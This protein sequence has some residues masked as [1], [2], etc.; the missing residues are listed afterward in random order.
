MIRILFILDSFPVEIYPPNYDINIKYINM[1]KVLNKFLLVLLFPICVCS[2][3]DNDYDFDNIDD[4]G[5]LSPALTLPIGS[6]NT[7]VLDFIH[8][9][10]IDEKYLEIGTDT[11]YVVYDG[12]MS[13]TPTTSIPDFDQYGDLLPYI[14]PVQFAFDGGEANID[15]DVFKDLESRGSIL[16]PSN[17]RVRCVISNYIGADIDLKI[18]SIKS[19]GGDLEKSA[20]FGDG[21][22]S[23]SIQ[24]G[25]APKAG[26][27]TVSTVVFDKD[28]GRMHELFSIAPER[29]SYDFSVDMNI[30]NDGFLVKDKFVDIDY[31][32]K[33][34]LTFSGGT[35][36]S[37]ADTL[38]FDL[39]GDDFVSSLDEFKLWIDYQNRL[40][41]SVELE[42]RFLDAS[43]NVIPG[44]TKRFSMSAAPSSKG[45]SNVQSVENPF[46]PLTR[47]NRPSAL[48]ATG[49]FTLEFASNEIDDAE[50]AQYIILYS[51]LKVTGNTE[52]NIHPSDYIALK[53]GA[54][55]KVNI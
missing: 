54:Y 53:L 50:K 18:N 33:I 10:G 7:S 38:D 49:S 19:Y 43:K 44:I 25:S 23:Y 2:C 35:E 3:V 55:L 12:S 16:Y 29:I 37:S 34:P 14:P 22:H 46:T 13:L 45:L 1:K 26:D 15:I 40:P 41:A 48:P 51:T 4:S 28:N 6:L 27:R 47:D 32:I 17:P 30:K 5:G 39:S 52:I 8:N 11:I 42:I 36:L 9:A 21:E 31:D 20:V 24:V